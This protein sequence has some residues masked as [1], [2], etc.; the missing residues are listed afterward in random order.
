MGGV[1]T[2]FTSSGVG[3]VSC[4][5]R[6]TMVA[7]S[8]T[9]DTSG[10]QVGC[11]GCFRGCGPLRKRRP[12]VPTIHPAAVLRDWPWRPIVVHDLKRALDL[13]DHSSRPREPNCRRLL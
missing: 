3:R 4:R 10:C 8:S 6:L 11:L 9:L 13:P 2:S 7:L 5:G 1:D 12:A